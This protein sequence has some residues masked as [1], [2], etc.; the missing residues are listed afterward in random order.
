MLARVQSNWYVRLVCPA[1][2]FFALQNPNWETT[3]SQGRTLTDM[4]QF[5]FLPVLPPISKPPFFRYVWLILSVYFNICLK[6]FWKGS[7]FMAPC[8]LQVRLP[9]W[10]RGCHGPTSPIF[11]WIPFCNLFGH[12]D[13]SKRN[14]SRINKFLWYKPTLFIV[15]TWFNRSRIVF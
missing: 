13:R 11:S 4:Q 5:F 3:L 12:S 1:F 2:L 10:R 8:T 14:Y 6:F 15:Q 9:F 7:N